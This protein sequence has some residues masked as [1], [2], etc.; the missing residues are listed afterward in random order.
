MT[1]YI[2]MLNGA[3]VPLSQEEAAQRAGEEGEWAA[4]EFVRVRLAA[5]AAIDAKA[6]QV[7]GRYITIAPGQEATYIMKAQQAHAFKAANYLG[8]V[9]GLVQS[10]A[11]ARGISAVA[12]CDAILSEEAAWLAK[13]AQIETA[14]RKWKVSI[15]DA[16]EPKDIRLSQA[17]AIE[18]LDA[19]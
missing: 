5:L 4:G 9:P 1:A 17:S 18:E 8:P 11:T 14:R 16:I 15:G 7:R 12:S 6:G 19:L 13:A 3:D 10:E 2:K